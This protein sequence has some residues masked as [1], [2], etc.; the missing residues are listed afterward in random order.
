MST[1]L[2]NNRKFIELFHN[3][4][5]AIMKPIEY[6]KRDLH[7]ICQINIMP[8]IIHPYKLFVKT[9]HKNE[10]LTN[11]NANLST[12]IYILFLSCDFLIF[13]PN[14]LLHL[15]SFF[16]SIFYQIVLIVLVTIW[17]VLDG[18]YFITW[19]IWNKIIVKSS[20]EALQRYTFW[21]WVYLNLWMVEIIYGLRLYIL[22]NTNISYK[23]NRFQPISYV[24]FG[25][26]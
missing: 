19:H 15:L 21:F 11:L 16:H 26:W 12:W 22:Y 17:A 23:L 6:K 4:W 1:I 9:L 14:H 8:N 10:A 5:E 2:N 3:Q 7:R 24:F 18:F 13:F 25:S 20:F